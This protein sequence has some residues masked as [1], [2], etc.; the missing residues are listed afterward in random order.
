MILAQVTTLKIDQSFIK[1]LPGDSKSCAITH[2]LLGLSK[3]LGMQ[4]V[5]EG[6]ETIE[7]YEFLTNE[8]CDL[9][10]G[11]YISPAVSSRKFEVLLRQSYLKPSDSVQ[12]I[13]SSC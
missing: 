9:I 7:Q 11:Y 6:V 1:E 4:V 10:Q 12:G 3:K 5:A 2:L 8:G 13:N